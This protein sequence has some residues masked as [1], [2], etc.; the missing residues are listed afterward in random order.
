MRGRSDSTDLAAEWDEVWA[1]Y[2]ARRPAPASLHTPLPPLASIPARPRPEVRRASRA[3]ARLRGALLALPLLAPLG[4][5]GASGAS[6]M[7][8][9]QAV[10]RQDPA[11]LAPHLDLPAVQ[12]GLRQSLLRDS[13]GRVGAQAPGPQAAAFLGGMAEEMAAAWAE[14]AALAEVARSRGVTQGAAAEGLLALRPVGLAAVEMPIGAA[15]GTAAPITLVLE[16]RDAGLA[17]RWQV[18]GVRIAAE[19]RA[20]WPAP[21]VRLSQ[22]R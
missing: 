15:S 18:T 2:D 5:L 13:L 21:P 12:S 16:L 20:A 4:W 7:D 8:V 19:P 17:P 9:A 10:E 22:L 11:A 14:P 6:L 3:A 1:D